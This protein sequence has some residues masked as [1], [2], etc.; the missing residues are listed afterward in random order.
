MDTSP[1]DPTIERAVLAVLALRS[2]NATICPSDVARSLAAGESD[3]RALMPRVRDAARR[4]ARAGSVRILQRGRRIDP[5]AD[6][7]GP[8]RIGREG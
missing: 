4:L 1:D 2:V 3:W 5:D 7:V 6:W 8:V